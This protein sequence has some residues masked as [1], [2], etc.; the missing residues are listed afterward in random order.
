MVGLVKGLNASVC[1]GVDQTQN[2]AKALKG[3]ARKTKLHGLAGRLGYNRSRAQI[4]R[5]QHNF[6]LQPLFRAVAV[7]IRVKNYTIEV[8]DIGRMPVLI[9]RTGIEDGLSAPIT[10]ESIAPYL[11]MVVSSGAKGVI[12]AVE[13]DLETAVGFLMDLEQRE[14]AAFGLQPDPV[15]S[16]RNL[17]S[18]CLESREFLLRQLSSLVGT[19]TCSHWKDRA[20]VGSTWRY[21]TWSGQGF[22]FQTSYEESFKRRK[23]R[24]QAYK[25]RY[26]EGLVF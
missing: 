2:A 11:G 13:T 3:Y 14:I 10:F 25:K 21:L 6:I 7:A 1:A 26:E 8:S 9:V 19:R 4:I 18:G 24:E 22:E 16:T 17:Q 23:E 5:D 20:R 15:E 12:S